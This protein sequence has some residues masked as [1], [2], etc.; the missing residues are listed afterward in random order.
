MRLSEPKDA[1]H[2]VR[3]WVAM[4]RLLPVENRP[5]EALSLAERATAFSSVSP[6][7]QAHA[8]RLKNEVLFQLRLLRRCEAALRVCGEGLR[9]C[10]A[11]PRLSVQRTAQ[12]GRVS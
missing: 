1:S 2:L 4:A 9:R 10:R 8:W 11:L 7:L 5:D 12:E 6:R 3:Q